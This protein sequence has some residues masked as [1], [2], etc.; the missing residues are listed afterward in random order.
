MEYNLK[1]RAGKGAVFN[2]NFDG[3]YFVNNDRE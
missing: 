1:E 3:C 2:N